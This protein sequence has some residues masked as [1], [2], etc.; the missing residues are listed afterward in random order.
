MRKLFRILAVGNF[1]NS[2]MR[3]QS[4]PE[5]KVLQCSTGVL[6]YSST[7]VFVLQYR[8][9]SHPLVQIKSRDQMGGARRD[10]DSVASNGRRSSIGS[11]RKCEISSLRCLMRELDGYIYISI[12]LESISKISQASL[13]TFICICPLAPRTSLGPIQ[14]NLT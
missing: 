2:P 3:V 7:R 9:C 10:G 6:E 4:H 13:F 14:L 11:K 12:Y 8:F 1:G 5:T